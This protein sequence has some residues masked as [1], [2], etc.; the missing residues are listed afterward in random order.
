MTGNPYNQVFYG[1]L[2]LLFAFLVVYTLYS[3]LLG[4]GRRRREQQDRHTAERGR[5]AHALGW[6]LDETKDGDIRYRIH[7]VDAAG[8][9]WRIEYDSDHSS[10]SSAPKLIFLMPALGARRLEWRLIDAA[11]HRLMHTGAGRAVIGGVLRLASVLGSTLQEHRD[12]AEQARDLQAGSVAFRRRFVLLG[13]RAAV[14][15]LLDRETENLILDWPAFQPSFS[16]AD[17][18]VSVEQGKAG[19]KA[20]L[21]CDGPSFE[22]IE[23]LA[24]LGEALAAR[25][26]AGAQR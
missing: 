25:L 8:R 26:A 23:H 2:G 9:A 19:L 15:R 18:C 22:V 7:G 11:Q 1:V 24:R 3:N 6:R 10:S 16:R 5:R 21:A 4:E 13:R 14:A 12:F 17:N 20:T